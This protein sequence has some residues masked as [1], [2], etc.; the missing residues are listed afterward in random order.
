MTFLRKPSFPPSLPPSL[1]PYLPP[2]FPPFLPPSLPSSLPP[3]CLPACLSAY[4][5]HSLPTSLSRP[6]PQRGTGRSPGGESK[7]CVSKMKNFFDRQLI[8]RWRVPRTFLDYYKLLT[9]DTYVEDARTQ[10][11][12]SI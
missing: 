3:P 7:E 4:L 2:Y 10:V 8:A 1:P 9:D 11:K 5:P 6:P 12:T